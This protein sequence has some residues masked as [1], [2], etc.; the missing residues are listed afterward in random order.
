MLGDFNVTKDTIDRSPPH[1][2]DLNVIATIRDKRHQ[3]GLLDSWRHAYPNYKVFTYRA[4][5]N[6]Q[7]IKSCLDRIYTTAQVAQHSFNWQHSATPVP[8]DHWL[9]SVK[10]A[11]CDT[12]YIGSGRWTWSISSLKNK[13][14]T[15]TIADRGVKLQI[16][17]ENTTQEPID[18]EITNPQ[19]LWSEYK[20]DIRAAAKHHN[21]E[22]Y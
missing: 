5:S 19:L 3:W 20:E 13:K 16:D 8:T 10:F 15:T 21:K 22:T 14:L 4:I 12:P 6:D 9:V 11:P 2:D 1:L 18:R 7:P 17:I